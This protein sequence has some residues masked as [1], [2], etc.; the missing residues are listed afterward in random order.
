M[1]LQTQS[2]RRLFGAT[3]WISAFASLAGAQELTPVFPVDGSAIRF[4]E[5][6]IRGFDWTGPAD[7][8]KYQIRLFGPDPFLSQVP[9]ETEKP[10]LKIQSIMERYFTD[11]S[12]FQWQI[13]Q[14]DSANNVIRTSSLASFKISNQ[15]TLIPTP[16]PAVW[17]T[18][19]GDIDG[20]ARVDSRDLFILASF[21]I[22]SDGS[23]RAADLNQDS[24]IDRNDLLIYRE[25]YGKPG[26]PP[27]A[28][29][30]IGVP[31]NL[32]FSPDSLVTIAETPTMEIQWNAP[33]YPQS[34]GFVYD[35]LIVPPYGSN[36]E[37]ESIA[38][39]SIKPF[40]T[41]MT[42]IGIYTVY[43]RARLDG[44]GAGEIASAKF[45]IAYSKPTTPTPTPV[46][47][48]ANI[49]GDS[50]T[51]ALDVGSFLQTFNT[52][53]GHMNFNSLADLHTDDKIDRQDLLL[54]QQYYQGRTQSAV[55]SPQWL[56]AEIPVIEEPMIGVPSVYTA[57][58]LLP[59][60]ELKLGSSNVKIA[61]AEALYLRLYFKPV[62]GAVDYFVSVY[63]K[64]HDVRLDFFTGGQTSFT[65][66]LIPLG[67]DELISIEV[68]A[69]GEGLQLGQK[70][71]PLW[72]VIPSN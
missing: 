15:T 66:K 55:D 19:S 62:A 68:Q 50:Q 54:F 27:P 60:Y 44:V 22:K 49:S 9:F 42:R 41:M 38:T 72:I 61:L 24:Q 12:D 16:T 29:A 64:N 23:L 20:S 70:S 53:K 10:P 69:A 31:R 59:P 58:D 36:I 11:G 3:L 57:V 32:R 14:L 21:W 52:Y 45:T 63:Y 35:M 47:Q 56:K 17:P 71:E 39:T 6:T 33:A 26:D 30:P 48:S 34:E 18:P 25:R 37:Y 5:L 7:A 2:I 13:E 65:E 40:Q 43:L 51:N 4:Q 1:K 8:V 28:Q 46:P 67:Y